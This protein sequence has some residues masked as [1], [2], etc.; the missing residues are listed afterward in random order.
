MGCVH[1][2]RDQMKWPH[3]TMCRA[4]ASFGIRERTTSKEGEEGERRE[5]GG[6]GENS[7]RKGGER[8]L[9]LGLARC[10]SDHHLPANSFLPLL[11]AYQ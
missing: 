8:G 5:E 4:Q 10:Q 7:G 3:P 11:L 2:V 6:G 1:F 9:L